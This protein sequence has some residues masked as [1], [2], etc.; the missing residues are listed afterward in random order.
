[1]K[2][3][4]YILFFT[5]ILSPFYSFSQI[6]PAELR[7]NWIYNII[8]QNV[9]F[10]GEESME[11]YSIGVFG[12]D[13]EVLPHLR[14]FATTQTIKGK[15]SEIFHYKRVSQIEKTDIL[16]VEEKKN[17]LIKSIFNKIKGTGTLLITYN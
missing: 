3:I 1:M 14:K 4:L 2:K 6:S 13:P 7:A 12:K 17:D 9:I 8:A 10:E 15:P 16:F 11:S 5:I